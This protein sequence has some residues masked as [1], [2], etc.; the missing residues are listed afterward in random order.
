M[1]EGLV[2]AELRTVADVAELDAAEVAELFGE[3]RAALVPLGD[4]SR[5][6]KVA[7][8]SVQG[9][10]RGGSTVISEPGETSRVKRVKSTSG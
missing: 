4:R 3:L 8:G 1:T 6:R 2:H 10:F 9:S 7:W 5:L